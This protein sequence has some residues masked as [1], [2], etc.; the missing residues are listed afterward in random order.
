[1]DERRS[2]GKRAQ[3]VIIDGQDTA[4]LLYAYGKLTTESLRPAAPD[5]NRRKKAP[6]A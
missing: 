6:K 1:M 5:R 2:R 3:F 4:R